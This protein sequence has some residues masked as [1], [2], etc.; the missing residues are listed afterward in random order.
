[1]RWL[2]LGLGLTNKWD[3]WS[4]ISERFLLLEDVS[5]LLL[6]DGWKFILEDNS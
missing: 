4:P 1:M 6:E 2:W 5:Y 3:D